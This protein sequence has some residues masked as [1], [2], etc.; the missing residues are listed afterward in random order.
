MKA[1]RGFA[2]IDLRKSPVVGI[3]YFGGL[4]VDETAE[5]LKISPDTVMCDWRLARI[6]LGRVGKERLARYRL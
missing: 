6:W 2:D 5:V 1:L 4:S 3:R